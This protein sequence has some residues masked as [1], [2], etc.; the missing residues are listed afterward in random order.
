MEEER[1]KKKDIVVLDEGI[2]PGGPEGPG[3]EWAC[4]W[5]MFS[6]IR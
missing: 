1:D 4:C 3:P 5:F 2:H 6:P